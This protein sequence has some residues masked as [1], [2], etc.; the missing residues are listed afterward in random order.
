MQDSYTQ[1]YGDT[2]IEFC[3]YAYGNSSAIFTPEDRRNWNLG[4]LEKNVF[5]NKMFKCYQENGLV[6]EFCNEVQQLGYQGADDDNWLLECYQQLKTKDNSN[7]GAEDI[8]MIEKVVECK[9]E[10]TAE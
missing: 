5:S 2:P 8:E 10:P 9:K 3:R 7:I 6:K 1:I 4:I